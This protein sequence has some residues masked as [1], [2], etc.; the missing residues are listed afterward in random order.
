MLAEK[1]AKEAGVADRVTVH[2]MDY[3]CLPSHW[4]GQFDAFV[5]VEMIEHVVRRPSF[6]TFRQVQPRLN[7]SFV[8]L[9]LNIGCELAQEVFLHCRL[10]T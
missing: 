3:R 10:G 6:L 1:R 7:A 2:L 5:S 8:L 9:V 4:K